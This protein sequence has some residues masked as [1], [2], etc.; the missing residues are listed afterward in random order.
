M[1]FSDLNSQQTLVTPFQMLFLLKVP[2]NAAKEEH[3]VLKLAE[4]VALRLD[5][6]SC[7][8]LFDKPLKITTPAKYGRGGRAFGL[9]SQL[10]WQPARTHNLWE[11]SK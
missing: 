6:T 4:E 2:L 11:Q 7:E 5:P 9:T 1:N 8:A 10:E 3:L